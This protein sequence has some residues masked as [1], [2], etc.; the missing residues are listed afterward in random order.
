[1]I[2]LLRERQP[3]YINGKKKKLISTGQ[4]AVMSARSRSSRFAPRRAKTCRHSIDPIYLRRIKA[5]ESKEFRDKQREKKRVEIKIEGG[6]NQEEGT[7]EEGTKEEGTKEEG[8]KEGT[9]EEGTKEEGTYTSGNM[10][11][12]ALRATK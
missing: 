4:T 2:F 11:Q 6:R 8:T 9:K 7:K 1:M 10:K 12:G 5:K 3:W